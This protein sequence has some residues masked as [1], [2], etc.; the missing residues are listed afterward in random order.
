MK[1]IFEYSGSMSEIDRV[2]I[3]SKLDRMALSEIKYGKLRDAYPDKV[4]AIDSLML[5]IKKY[6]ETGNT[7]HLIDVSNYAMIEFMFPSIKDAFFRPLDSAG[8]PGRVW[9]DSKVPTATPNNED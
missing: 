1:L 8:S 2:F 7:E 4:S 3:Q 6:K 5:R 9:H